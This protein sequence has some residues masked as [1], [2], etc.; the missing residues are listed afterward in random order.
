MRKSLIIF[1]VQSVLVV[2][3][4]VYA[5]VQRTEV[6]KMREQAMENEY[7]AREARAEAEKQRAIAEEQMRIAVAQQAL[8]QK[9]IE[10]CSKKK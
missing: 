9:A 3:F 7:R 2:M 6:T 8:A 1:A 4:L 5:L 10:E